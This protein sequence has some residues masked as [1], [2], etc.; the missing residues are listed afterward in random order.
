[1]SEDVKTTEGL[2]LFELM[3]DV[4]KDVANVSVKS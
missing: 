1:M 3:N 4:I 2:S